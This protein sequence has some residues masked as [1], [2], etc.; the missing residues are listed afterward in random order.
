MKRRALVAASAAILLIGAGLGLGAFPGP[1]MP[2][3]APAAA[4]DGPRSLVEA[5]AGL[6]AVA[7]A[8]KLDAPLAKLVAG[9]PDRDRTTVLVQSLDPVDLAAYSDYVHRF[10]WPAGEDV[11]LLEVDPA[12]LLAIAALPGV[13]AIEALDE[14]LARVE[15]PDAVA[16]PRA[17][18]SEVLRARRETAPSWPQTARQLKEKAAAGDSAGSATGSEA[19]DSKPASPAAPDAAPAPR[20]DGWYDV[21]SGHSAREAWDMG[22]KGEGVKV[23]VLDN[24]V[25]FA[26][27][28]MQGTWAVLPEG[29]P[30]AGWPQVF[31]PNVGMFR[32]RDLN[33][34]LP[35]ENRSTRTASSGMIELYQDSPVTEREVGGAMKPTACFRPR[36][37][38]LQGTLVIPEMGP[39]ACDFVVPTTSKS[40][41]LRYGHHPDTVAAT[42]AEDLSQSIYGVFPGVILVD[43][44]VAGTYDTV[45]VDI[46]NDRDFTDEKPMSQAD[47][48]GWRDM[49][50]DAVA[51][52]SAGLLYFIADGSLPFPAAWVWGLDN[53]I[54]EA[55]RFIGIL[56]AGGSHGTLCASNVVGQGR[57]T[58]PE[59]RQLAFRDLPGNGEPVSTNLGM[60]PESRMVSVGDVYSYGNFA[61]AWRY[62]TLGHDPA[63][64]DDDIQIASNSYGWSDVDH[65]G[66]EPDGRLIDYYVRTFGENTSFLIATGNGGPGFGTVASPAPSVGIDVAA[67]TQFGSTGA[68]SITETSQITFGDIIPFSN[69]G[70]GS[71]GQVGPNLAADG[72]HAAGAAP[73]NS[74]YAGGS[75]GSY[76]NGTWGGTS[77]STPV[78]AGA[79]AL[80]YQ[81]F[82]AGHGRWPTWQ[83]S[84]ALL[85]GGARFNGYD[86]LTMGAG[87]LDAGDSARIASG[88]HGV[89]ALPGEWAAGNYRGQR[90]PAFA[91]FVRPGDS[92]STTLTLVNPSDRPVEVTLSAQTLRRIGSTPGELVTDN[93]QESTA[94]PV[95][96]YLV[97]IGDQAPEGTDLMVAR[98][99]FPYEEFDLG[100]DLVADNAFTA[101]VMQHTDIDGD[102]KLWV[103]KNGNGAVNYRYLTAFALEA[104][105]SDQHRD[106]NAEPGAIT[107]AIPDE[108]FAGEL[109]YYGL[110]CLVDGAAP[111]P[112]QEIN[113]KIALIER[114]VCTFW[115]KITNAQQHG[116][117][118]VVIFTDARPVVTMGGDDTGITV[119]GVMIERPAG[120]EL[121]DVLLEGQTVSVS[122]HEREGLI[123]KGLDGDPPVVYGESEIQ[124]WEYMTMAND[125]GLRNHWAIS[126]QHPRERQADGLYLALWH[127]GRSAAITH[128]H[129]T[130]RL[131]YYAYRDWDAIDLSHERITIPPRGK[132]RVQAT[133]SVP[134]DAPQGSIQGAI[135]ADYARG[136][137]EV[138]IDGPG[139][140]EMEGRRLVIPVIATV[141]ADYDWQ[142]SIVLGGPEADDR[143]APYN[144]GAMWGTFKWNWRPESGDWRFHFV[145][146]L[147]QPPEGT[148]WLFRTQWSDPGAQQSDIDTRIWGPL[149]DRFSNPAHTDNANE[150]MADPGHYGPYTMGLKG[151]SPYLVQDFTVWPFNTSTGG[152]DDWLSLPAAEGLHEVMLHNV[153]FSGKQL[154]MPFQTT[155]SSIRVTAPKPPDGA[156]NT[157]PVWGGG[158]TTLSITSQMDLPDFAVQGFG[159]SLPVEL[160]DHEVKQDATDD[161]SSASFKHDIVLDD[162]AGRFTV[163]T[164]GEPDNDLDVFIMF[165]ANADGTFEYPAERLIEGTGPTADEQ[166]SVP[167]LAAPGAYQVWVHGLTVPNGT[168]RVDVTIDIV[169]GQSIRI[170]NAPEDLLAGQTAMID[171]CA[172]LSTLEGEDGPAN[173]LV[174]FGPAEAPSMFQ[175]S[176]VWNRNPPMHLF[177]PSAFQSFDLLAPLTESPSTR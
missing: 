100:A 177:M 115:E 13:Y 106:H 130:T 46:D 31:D 30:Y 103:D 78:A 110:G 10:T 99:T 22:F 170:E 163:T 161:R 32:A 109:A 17:I 26:H 2:W 138:P 91:K 102:G 107:A 89:Y 12:D 140:W 159:M 40:G 136:E 156:S 122:M 116:A 121:R 149:A 88:A 54:P 64:A 154:E 34:N 76:A 125:S 38:R 39:E 124:P 164:K 118:G 33:P 112:E 1:A 56:Y 129:I 69:R 15:P 158:C 6:S 16:P 126:V 92:D 123:T 132:A 108:G 176:V 87:V 135:F 7:P 27:Q 49:T 25:D 3:P 73:I 61:P 63:R 48:L 174:I 11:A 142:G 153:L 80:A 114:G 152:N 86:V 93:E 151:R 145:D 155:V 148:Y 67:S 62:V 14:D 90:H 146:A 160:L 96:D 85:M 47:P 84:Q 18:S 35:P 127:A 98:G 4:E 137:G 113:E 111:P 51:D 23:A 55:G 173:G 60:A 37:L 68:D 71:D 105:W 168:T 66:W 41:Q 171:V 141:G 70:P 79:A 104:W 20:T 143:D 77:R 169:S 119:P 29:H 82:K 134:E 165:D 131:D 147:T 120:L 52:L 5:V 57:L 167:G 45:Y 43:E 24:A 65:D 44:Q 128:T 72:A 59:G 81:A 139:G 101:G 75:D 157:I 95:P 150:N 50:G 19:A 74:Y 133:L 162:P 9:K 144:N 117:I 42:L 94:G 166:V 21:R 83:E 58:V 175:M 36:N 53:D 97:P 172:D 28:D 8:A